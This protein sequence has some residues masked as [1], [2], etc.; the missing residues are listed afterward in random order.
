MKDKT[1][2]TLKSNIIED[3][4]QCSRKEIDSIY[5]MLKDCIKK[6]DRD[7][8]FKNCRDFFKLIFKSRKDKCLFFINDIEDSREK[9][10]SIEKEELRKY[11]LNV[12]NVHRTFLENVQALFG[13]S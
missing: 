10:T 4:S 6:F 8:L 1:Y 9:L 5:Q 3:L 7:D 13:V 11:F 12:S 2:E